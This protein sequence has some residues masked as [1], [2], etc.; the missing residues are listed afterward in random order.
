MEKGATSE[1]G[2]TFNRFNEFPFEIRHMIW[3]ESLP[4]VE[5]EVLV[6]KPERAACWD[7]DTGPT[8][9]VDFPAILHV[10]QESRGVALEHV[11]IRED[12]DNDTWDRIMRNSLRD[13]AALY[14]SEGISDMSSEDDEDSS[15]VD[16]D[17]QSGGGDDEP[18][19]NFNAS[20]GNNE[21]KPAEDPPSGDDVAGNDLD[22]HLAA[23]QSAE[24]LSDEG[25]EFSDAHSEHT[26]ELGFP[27][28]R[29]HIVCRRFRPELDYIFVG[30][31]SL[32]AFEHRLMKTKPWLPQHLVL[33]LDSCT[34][35]WMRHPDQFTEALENCVQLK[36]AVLE[37]STTFSPTMISTF[38]LDPSTD[39][40]KWQNV[41]M[42]RITN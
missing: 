21:V 28:F 13:V 38:H 8:V 12:W 33:S 35:W 19:G 39:L 31:D 4:P 29:Y 9:E 2:T 22:D 32:A 1:S 40:S 5:A 41:T 24:Q 7:V 14:H 10:C 23:S 18:A 11:L 15:T 36:I 3:M 37:D 26:S 6:Y 27:G 34:T 30:D 42:R 25:N 16:G 17:G 20:D